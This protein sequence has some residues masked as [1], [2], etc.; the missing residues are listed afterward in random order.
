MPVEPLVTVLTIAIVANVA[1]MLAVLVAP[2][3]RGRRLSERATARPP[4]W[5]PLAS[6][7]VSGPSRRLVDLTPAEPSATILS[8]EAAPPGA[9]ETA[10][11]SADDFDSP[12]E[13][14]ATEMEPRPT[15]EIARRFPVVMPH[16]PHAGRTIEAFLSSLEAGPVEPDAM[17]APLET[18][19]GHPTP[20]D[21][22]APLDDET[23]LAPEGLLDPLTGLE[24]PLG[25]ERR[26]REENDRLQR[27]RRPV[28]AVVAEIDGL[29]RLAER[30][31]SEPPRRVIPA[32]A[33][34][35]RREARASDRVARVAWA[36][37]AVLL[38][39][40]DE[41]QAIN[42]VERVRSACD[43][44]LESGAVALRL[45]VGWASP[46]GTGDL[47]TAARL[48]EERMQAER[49]SMPPLRIARTGTD[50]RL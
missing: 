33:D 20:L 2:A 50:P 10:A 8:R 9:I 12:E 7:A 3:I 49:R 35:F 31:G 32:V 39:E 37:F 18:P 21:D 4:E 48:A 17:P 42:Y 23:R 36:R 43:R 24:G 14:F 11:P 27:Y 38:P 47:A 46:N 19:V 5:P 25:W 13:T 16:D 44:W 30:F 1:L 40:T 45:S 41:V 26:L 28:T 15:D 34:A 29:H 6:P 22:G